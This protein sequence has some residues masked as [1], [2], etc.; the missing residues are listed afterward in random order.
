[1]KL[2]KHRYSTVKSNAK[3]S[4]DGLH[5]YVLKRVWTENPCMATV[6]ML[7]PTPADALIWDKSLM[8]IMNYLVEKGYGGFY[9]VN[10][11]SYIAK[12]EEE[13]IQETTYE[14]RYNKKTDKWISTAFK[15]SKDIYIAWGSNKNRIR[16][17]K[18]VI[19]ILKKLGVNTVFRF[20]SPDGSVPHISRS[21][22]D[23]I[24]QSILV[25]NLLN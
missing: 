21:K 9:V 7:N 11:F 5:R 2:I 22:T 4:D 23:K 14:E 16:R 13:L 19:D 3:F 6:I 25:D 15:N 17:I 10:L 18:T 24:A 20:E 12:S 1:M 8:L